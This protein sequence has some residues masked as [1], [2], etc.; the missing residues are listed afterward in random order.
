MEIEDKLN[1]AIELFLENEFYDNY[2]I[3]YV[4]EDIKDVDDDIDWNKIIYVAVIDDVNLTN[5]ELWIKFNHT[6]LQNHRQEIKSEWE[7]EKLERQREYW[8]DRF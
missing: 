6:F 7:Q 8:N 1:D 3:V 5:D 2:L 4:D